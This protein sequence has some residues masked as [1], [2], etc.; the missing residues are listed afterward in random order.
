MLN[1]IGGNW[2]ISTLADS[3]YER[4]NA[5]NTIISNAKRT[6]RDILINNINRL[7]FGHLNINSLQ[8]KFDFLCG[9]I[10]GPIDVF[11]ITESKLDDIFPHGQFLFDRFHTL[12]R[13][14]YNKNEGGILLYVREGIPAKILNHDFPSAENVFVEIKLHKKKWLINCSHNPNKNNIKNH[15]EI[16]NKALDSFTTKYENIILLGDFNVCVDD[17][18]M[19]NFCN[20]YSLNSHIKQPICIK[21]PENPSCI[22]LI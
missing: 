21:N 10:K 3:Y 22:A 2:D 18:T 8:T 6:L 12:F 15:L 5:S 9:K 19:R 4:E 16:V 20:C 14:D 7:V 17:E 11:V 1:V 13:F